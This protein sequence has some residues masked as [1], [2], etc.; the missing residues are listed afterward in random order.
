MTAGPWRVET[1]HMNYSPDKPEG[2]EDIIA[3]DG[4]HVFCCGHDYDDCGVIATL[5]DGYLMA[6]APDLLAALQSVVAWA[7]AGCPANEVSIFPAA[8]DAIRKATEITP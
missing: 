2:V 6:A 4:T 1:W 3:A 7:D 8:R 5:E